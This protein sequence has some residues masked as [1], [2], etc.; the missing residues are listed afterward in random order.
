MLMFRLPA[1]LCL[2]T[3]ALSGA[4]AQ[5]GKTS[6]IV[7]PG[8]AT[9]GRRDRIDFPQILAF[10]DPG[11]VFSAHL[12]KANSVAVFSETTAGAKT[13]ILRVGNAIQDTGKVTAI[14]SVLSTN[15]QSQAVIY[16]ST[17]DRR[18]TSHD[19]LL[20][21]SSTAD[22]RTVVVSDETVPDGNGQF[23]SFATTSINNTGEI[24]FWAGIKNG[25][26]PVS[27][28]GVF[29]GHADGTLSEIA[30]SAQVAPGETNLFYSIGFPAPI[31]TAG[32]VCFTAEISDSHFGTGNNSGLYRASSPNDIIKIAR[33]YDPAPGTPYLFGYFQSATLNNSGAIAFFATLIDDA[34]ALH[35]NGIFRF[36][37]ETGLTAIAYTGQEAPGTSLDYSDFE[38]T[39]TINNAGQVSYVGYY[40]SEPLGAGVFVGDGSTQRSLALTGQA[41]PDGSIFT[42]FTA[43]RINDSG[44]VAF[45]AQLDGSMG[46]NGIFLID[47]SATTKVAKVGDVVKGIEIAQLG[48]NPSL[49]NNSGQLAYLA[50]DSTGSNLRYL[51]FAYR[52]R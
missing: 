7:A 52:S 51:R 9:P 31:N 18:G 50:I 6:V 26:P 44:F 32:Q 33:S 13:E 40:P 30:R 43:A 22:V 46:F 4:L 37:D 29:I 11:I 36:N 41:A 45:A 23:G 39:S 16:A 47:G 35:G 2:L 27:T 5:N 42:G 1:L 10:A 25:G 15:D 24:G 8:D 14:T 12:E 48:Y 20:T 38:R 3:T 34:G 17:M 28:N 19:A 49:F 21:G